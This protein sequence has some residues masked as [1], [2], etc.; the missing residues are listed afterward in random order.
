MNYIVFNHL[1]NNGK[2][3]LKADEV[4]KTIAEGTMFD[5]IDI[6]FEEQFPHW[7]KGDTVYLVGGDGTLNSFANFVSDKEL[8]CKVYYVPAG[9]GN[10]FYRDQESFAKDGMIYLNEIVKNLPTVFV[11]GMEKKFVN[12]IGFG[13]DG[14]CCEVGDEIRAKQPD[15]VINYSGIA[16]KGLLFKFKPRNA[17]VIVDGKSATYKKVWIAPAM[18]GKFYGGGM[19]VAPAQ[20][21]YN[22]ERT[23]TSVIMHGPKLPVLMAFP[24]IFKGEHINKKKLIAIAEGK[25]ITVIFDRPTALQIDGE[26]V[27]NVTEY[28]VRA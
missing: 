3:K 4:S 16:V 23:L 18:K 13:I 11:N 22:A 20:D 17:T 9:S 19:K 21:R 27:L 14:Y 6:P 8:L 7:K 26:T 12:G 25:E 10:D 24:S 15:A 28:T 5:V 1:S 2:G